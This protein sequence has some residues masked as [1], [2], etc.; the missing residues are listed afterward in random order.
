MRIQLFF[1]LIIIYSFTACS[2][3]KKFAKSAE[4]SLLSNPE[5]KTAHIGISIYDPATGKYVYDYQGDHYFIPASNTKLL[6]CYAAMKYLGDSLEGLKVEDHGGQLLIFPT[7]DPTLLH[8]DFK[9]QPVIDFLKK[10]ENNPIILID[11][12]WREKSLGFGWAWDDYESSYMAERSALPVYGNV[13]TVSG[14]TANLQFQPDLFFSH[15]KNDKGNSPEFYLSDIRRARDR[16]DFE[17][18]RVSRQ[19]SE[20][21]I[22]FIT[23]DS[24]SILLINQSL[25]KDLITQSHGWFAVPPVSSAYKIHSQPTD[26]LLKITMHRSDNFFAEQT[27]LMVSEKLLGLMNDGKIIDTLLKTDYKDMPQKPKWVDGSGLSRYNLITPR[28][29][30]FLLNK[31]KNEFDWNR[32]TTILP[33]GGTGTF[34]NFYKNYAGRFYGKTGTLSNQVAMSGYIKSKSGKWLICSVLVNNAM[35]SAVNVRKAVEQFVKGVAERY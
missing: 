16:N 32:I 28:D 13:L 34:S 12:S 11:T 1:L 29:F 23:N 27:L 4:A 9:N 21:S 30:V 22:P 20:A 26:S 35:T 7:G 15:L 18:A 19:K 24:L 6:M 17:A 5:L 2:P 14:N 8:P 25:H 33:T 31:M 10:H 3:G